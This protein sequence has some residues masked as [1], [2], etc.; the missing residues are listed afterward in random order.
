MHNDKLIE[1]LLVSSGKAPLNKSKF[2][3]VALLTGKAIA[4]SSLATAAAAITT[5]AVTIS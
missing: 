2:Y 5:A 3:G 1:S 4:S